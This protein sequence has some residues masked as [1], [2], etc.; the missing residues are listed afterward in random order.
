M[1]KI[2]RAIYDVQL[3]IKAKEQELVIVN[4]ELKTLRKQLDTLE[5]IKDDKLT[6]NE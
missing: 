2:E 1:N 5:K 6:P 4:A 3:H